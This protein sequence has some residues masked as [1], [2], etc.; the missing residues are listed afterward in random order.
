M[1]RY[2]CF[3]IENITGLDVKE[4]I[5]EATRETS[6]VANEDAKDK[7]LTH[8]P[9]ETTETV[10]AVVPTKPGESVTP[11]IIVTA[12][13]ESEVTSPVDV[14]TEVP[15]DVGAKVG[16]KCSTGMHDCSSNGTCISLEGTY[17]CECN[18]G[19]EGDGRI[20]AGMFKFVL[21]FMIKITCQ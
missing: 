17:D 16:D 18:L 7:S 3:R 2:N 11:S 8:E 15:T 6:V 14:L 4:D 21:C 20:C 1:L 13:T 12:R 10:S 19:Y 9:F 5:V